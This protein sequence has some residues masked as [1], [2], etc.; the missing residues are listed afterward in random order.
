MGL[1]ALRDPPVVFLIALT[2]QLTPSYCNLAPTTKTNASA[3]SVGFNN[4]HCGRAV[5]RNLCGVG[6]K[7][8]RE[9]APSVR[10]LL[11]QIEFMQKYPARIG[12]SS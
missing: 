12:L 6:R 9:H 5:G 7:E 3:G 2:L 10:S 8:G 1:R 11:R 4:A